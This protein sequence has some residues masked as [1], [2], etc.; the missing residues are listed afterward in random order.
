MSTL[1][2]GPSLSEITCQIEAIGGIEPGTL[3][4][5]IQVQVSIDWLLIAG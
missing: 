4:R 2:P 3:P 1:T 5:L